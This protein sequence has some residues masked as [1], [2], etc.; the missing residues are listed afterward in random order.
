MFCAPRRPPTRSIR[1]SW[2]PRPS[3]WESPIR[4]ARRRVC[5]GQALHL[6]APRWRGVQG[7]PV[8][9]RSR[10]HWPRCLCSCS[11]SNRWRPELRDRIDR[12]EDRVAVAAAPPLPLPT[13]R[14]SSSSAIAPRCTPCRRRFPSP[15]CG[16]ALRAHASA[17]ARPAF[18]AALLIGLGVG[19]HSLVAGL[20]GLGAVAA[21]LPLLARSSS[22]TRL[23]ALSLAAFA[24][25]CS[26]T[27]IFRCARAPCSRHLI[28]A[29]TMSCGAM[30]APGADSGGWCPRRPSPRR[31]RSCTAMP[32]H[33]ICPSCPSR[34]W[35]RSSRSWPRRARIFC[36]A[37]QLRAWSVCSACGHRGVDGGGAGRRAGSD[38]SRY[39]RLFGSGHRPH[40]RPVRR[41]AF[42][43]NRLHSRAATARRCGAGLPGG[44][45]FAISLAYAIPWP[46]PRARRRLRGPRHAR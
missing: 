38:Q 23:L 24:V 12:Q 25:G 1:P 15:P 8:A 7:S 20:V 11:C 32:R 9:G 45:A 19:N 17:D 44:S 29:W 27:P 37:G 21:A 22:R 36:C 16:L 26:S 41:R 35:E 46:A 6:A 10:A 14:A 42:R 13:R 4:P 30:P 39:S 34:N 33:G 40:R 18:V 3:A 5:F 43:R 28:V 31:P 2:P